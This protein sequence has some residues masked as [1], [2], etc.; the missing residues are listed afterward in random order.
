[1]EFIIRELR[2]D[3]DNKQFLELQ[4]R[5][6]AKMD[7]YESGFSKNML[8]DSVYDSDEE[9]PCFI[10]ISEGKMV[11][12]AKLS[13]EEEYYD[14]KKTILILDIFVLKEYQKYGIGSLLVKKIKEYSLGRN[15]NFIGAA[16][17]PGN[18]QAR[19]FFKKLGFDEYGRQQF[20][21]PL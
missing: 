2:G 7:T 19:Q 10:A 1:M 14:D 5:F 20:V 9:E 6:L 21:M 12:Y 18:M 4:R 8:L 16:V 13:Y 15:I 3:D 11:A 17:I